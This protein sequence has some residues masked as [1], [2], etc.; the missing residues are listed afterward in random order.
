VASGVAAKNSRIF[1][2]PFEWFHFLSAAFLGKKISAS[3]SALNSFFQNDADAKRLKKSGSQSR[4]LEGLGFFP[5][6][7]SAVI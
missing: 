1:Q 5:T 6:S 7:A 2:T 4:I 3:R